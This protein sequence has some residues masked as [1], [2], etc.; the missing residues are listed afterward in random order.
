[1][2][3]PL[4]PGFREALSSPLS[5]ALFGRRSR[6]FFRGAAIPDGPL[7]YTSKQ[8]PLPLS[9]IEQMLLL[10]A[11]AGNTGW[12]YL[13][14]HN[15]LYAPH[16]ANYAGAAGGRTFASAA[17]FHTSELFFTD[18]TGIYLLQTRDAPSL[19]E[20]STDGEV[21]VEELLEAHRSRILK[22]SDQRLYLPREEPYVN[23]HNLW[24]ANQPASTLLIPVC[25]LAQHQIL[26]L[27]FYLQN[28]FVIYD[29][30]HNERIPG[31]ERF[32]GIAD[33]ENPFPMTFVE[34]LSMSEC[35]AEIAMSCYAVT[36]MLQAMGLGGWMYDG[37]DQYAVLGAS[38]NPDV[39]GL[40]FR[41]DAREDWPMANPTGIEGVFGGHCP[42]HFADMRAAVEAV[43]KRKFGHGGPYHPETPGPWRQSARVRGSA[44]AHS[45]EFVECVTLM[46]QYV[47]DRF[48]KFPGTVPSVMALTY[49]QAHH[50][51][52][53]FYDR[54]FEPGAYLETH[55]NHMERWHQEL[56]MPL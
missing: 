11:A 6:R 8:G 48:G 36:L 21:D 25:D 47:Y 46:A 39:P 17:G 34:Q 35:A 33:V 3:E 43:V 19:A 4:P 45:E 23:G 30:V 7:A 2:K 13:I 55:K 40:G 28:G 12:N 32:A 24:C 56:P 10:T 50:L 22:L 53:E 20:I 26:G 5:E 41:Y 29:D 38:G 15:P 42:P 9:E 49:L 14:M 37:M 44:E 1:M 27:C 54:H 51:D 18:D 16:V 31:L 52:L